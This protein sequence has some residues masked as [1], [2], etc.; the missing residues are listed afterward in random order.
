MMNNIFKKKM[1]TFWILFASFYLIGEIF[2]L[3]STFYIDLDGFNAALE[4]FINNGEY[5]NIFD[6]F[7]TTGTVL[8]ICYV[9]F[10]LISILFLVFAIIF[11]VKTINYAKRNKRINN[12]RVNNNLNSGFYSS[13]DALDEEIKIGEEEIENLKSQIDNLNKDNKEKDD[14]FN[15]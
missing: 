15:D 3:I 6:Y 5:F 10:Y 9:V 8:S 2:S 7:S 1:I 11:T 14:I 12:N 13:D 4:A